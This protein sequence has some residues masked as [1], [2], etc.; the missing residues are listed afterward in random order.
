MGKIQ[1][2]KLQ[3][4][5]EISTCI[6]QQIYDKLIFLDCHTEQLQFTSTQVH[7][8]YVT[9]D[10]MLGLYHEL[11]RTFCIQD[12]D[13]LFSSLRE[14][15]SSKVINLHDNINKGFQVQVEFIS[16]F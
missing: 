15:K 10:H 16:K 11:S 1:E 7:Q 12:Q 14:V 8:L 4:I 6:E 5:E 2:A 13:K 3:G 9:N